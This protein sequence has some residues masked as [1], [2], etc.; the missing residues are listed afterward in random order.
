MKRIIFLLIFTVVIL[1]CNKQMV[2]TK[3]ENQMIITKKYVGQ[4]SYYFYDGKYTNIVTDQA[5]F[6]VDDEISIPDSVHC[7][8]RTQPCYLNLHSAIKKNLERKY[9]SFTEIEYRVKTW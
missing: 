3:Y 1:G 5:Y 9:F 7:Y 6:K 2:A 8:I 4:L